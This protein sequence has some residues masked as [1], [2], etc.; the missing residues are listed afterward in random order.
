MVFLFRI[1]K[2]ISLLC[3]CHNLSYGETLSGQ[4][5]AWLVEKIMFFIHVITN[6]QERTSYENLNLDL[7]VSNN[8]T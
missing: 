4:P 6:I 3:L 2:Q 5:G 1:E 7:W 8:S